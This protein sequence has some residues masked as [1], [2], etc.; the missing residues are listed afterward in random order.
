MKDNKLQSKTTQQK[1]IRI[2]NELIDQIQKLAD[3]NERDFSSQIRYML[4]E[5]IKIKE[6]I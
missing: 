4:K 1:T 3:Q 6:R 2:E 5:Y